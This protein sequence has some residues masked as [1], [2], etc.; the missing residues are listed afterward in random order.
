MNCTDGKIIAITY[1]QRLEAVFKNIQ[2]FLDRL[3]AVW[4]GN[5]YSSNLYL[6]ATIDTDGTNYPCHRLVGLGKT[7]S[8][9]YYKNKMPVQPYCSG[10]WAQRIC[11]GLC[12]YDNLCVSGD[13]KRFLCR[14][15]EAETELAFLAALYIRQN[16]I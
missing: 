2:V 5:W 8:D 4:A 9:N 6:L 14:I 1:K 10:C 12:L 16:I 13:T 15:Y 7:Y 3:N 11:S